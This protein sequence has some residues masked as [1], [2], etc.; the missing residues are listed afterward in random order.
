MGGKHGSH[1]QALKL[2]P[3]SDSVASIRMS[4]AE[5]SHVAMANVNERVQS[6]HLLEGG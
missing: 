4:P 3:D 2:L 6:H 5:A 1:T